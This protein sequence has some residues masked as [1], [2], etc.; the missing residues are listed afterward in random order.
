MLDVIGVDNI[1]LRLLDERNHKGFLKIFSNKTV[2][3]NINYDFINIDMK[4]ASLYDV[5][6]LYNKLKDLNYYFG[7]MI[8]LSGH[9]IGYIDGIIDSSKAYLRMSILPDFIN[10][11][12]LSTIFEALNTYLFKELNVSYVY[13]KHNKIFGDIIKKYP[14]I[15]VREKMFSNDYYFVLIRGLVDRLFA[16]DNNYENEYAEKKNILCGTMYYDDKNPLKYSTTY[17]ALNPH[18]TKDDIRWYYDDRVKNKKGFVQYNFV[19]KTKESMF[20]FIDDY[21]DE[22]C[23]YYVGFSKVLDNISIKVNDYRIEMVTSNIADDFLRVMYVE[24]KR[25]GE[26]YG[27]ENAKRQYDVILNEECKIKYYFIYKDNIPIGYLSAYLDG[28]ILKLEDF[29]I[30]KSYR[31]MGYGMALFKE[32]AKKYKSKL[33]YVVTS[34]CDDAKDIYAHIGLKCVGECHMLR[35]IF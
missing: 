22:R 15:L 23:L 12:M 26:A 27:R 32:V 21:E 2:L 28:D 5:K 9:I 7:Y 11:N 18:Y 3:K 20:S 31:G 13:L 1:S 10:H 33:I 35:K 16:I 6:R 30:S 19:G 4:C 29:I 17:L 34:A 25:F 14:F 8:Y 24:S